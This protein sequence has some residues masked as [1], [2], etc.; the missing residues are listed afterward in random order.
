M[1]AALLSAAVLLPLSGFA[2]P[3]PSV[4]PFK[5]ASVLSTIN[6]VTLENSKP[7]TTDWQIPRAQPIS[8]RSKD[9]LR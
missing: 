1:S 2:R 4:N 6:P 7:G 9:T 5:H 8:M 3:L